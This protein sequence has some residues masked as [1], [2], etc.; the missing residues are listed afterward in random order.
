MARL[1]RLLDST[2]SARTFKDSPERTGKVP[3]RELCLRIVSL[4]ASLETK[5]QT[6]KPAELLAE[7]LSA[8]IQ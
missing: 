8:R 3:K 4:H 1:Q 7:G 2:I 5:G 6:Y